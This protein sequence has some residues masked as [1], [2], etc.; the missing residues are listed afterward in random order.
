LEVGRNAIPN[1]V[2]GWLTLYR[3]TLK[4]ILAGEKGLNALLPENYKPD[5]T[6]AASVASKVAA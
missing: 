5:V 6:R 4:R 1:A 2:R 3:D